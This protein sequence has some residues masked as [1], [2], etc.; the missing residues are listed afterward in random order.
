MTRA[1]DLKGCMEAC[2]G[3]DACRS[4]KY[5]T[6][7]FLS[8]SAPPEDLNC[9]MCSGDEFSTGVCDGGSRKSYRSMNDGIAVSS[10]SI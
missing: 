2:I 3:I 9:M 5:E 4:I 8:G 7:P 10:N 1:S 6:R